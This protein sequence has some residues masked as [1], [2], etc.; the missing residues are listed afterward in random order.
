MFSLS[1]G[2]YFAWILRTVFLE[3]QAKI[4][5]ETNKNPL[6]GFHCNLFMNLQD[7]FV[8]ILGCVSEFKKKKNSNILKAFLNITFSE[9]FFFFNFD[10]F[11][12]VLG[13][14]SSL[15]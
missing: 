13:V 8:E 4:Q 5:E 7:H 15:V 2:E 1:L 6:Q 10:I 14:F 11:S 9:V 3:I 12:E